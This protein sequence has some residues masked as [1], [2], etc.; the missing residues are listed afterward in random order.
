[1]SGTNLPWPGRIVLFAIVAVLAAALLWPEI[2]GRD[3][4]SGSALLM[5]VLPLAGV[6][7]ATRRGVGSAK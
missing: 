3:L 4:M 6:L 2:F 5:I 1:V 7:V